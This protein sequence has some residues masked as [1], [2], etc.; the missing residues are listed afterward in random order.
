MKSQIWVGLPLLLAF[1]ISGCTNKSLVASRVP[2]AELLAV[3][4]QASL[5]AALEAGGATVETGDSVL[6]PFFTPEGSILKVNGA[7]VQVFE[8]ESPEEM[9]NEASQ[10]SSDGGSIGTSMVTWID[11]L[12]SI[13]R[14]ILLSSTWEAIRQCWICLKEL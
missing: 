14:G 13:K 3:A 7:D 6:Q 10:V 12:I 2:T 5:T 9:E 1:L 11:A 8:Y 4:D